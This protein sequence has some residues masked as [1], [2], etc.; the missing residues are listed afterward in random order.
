MKYRGL[1]CR[2]LRFRALRLGGF[3]PR[4]A[5]LGAVV[6]LCLRCRVRPAVAPEP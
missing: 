6:F 1:G 5:G 4:V 2:V 3:E